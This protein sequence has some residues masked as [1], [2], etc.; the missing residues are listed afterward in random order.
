M[1]ITVAGEKTKY[2]K[3]KGIAYMGKS[4]EGQILFKGCQSLTTQDTT[5]AKLIAIR[6]ATQKAIHFGFR[7]LIILVRDKD[8]VRVWS[9]THQARWQLT[10]ILVDLKPLKQQYGLYVHIQS[11]HPLILTELNTMARKASNSFVNV[12]QVSPPLTL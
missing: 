12:F 11:A 5:M 6:E 3:W 2:G 4:K 7:K 1:L 8:I 10:P 9:N